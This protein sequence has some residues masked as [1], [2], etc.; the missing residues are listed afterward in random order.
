MVTERAIRG[1]INGIGGPLID[2][3]SVIVKL[4]GIVLIWLLKPFFVTHSFFNINVCPL[5]A[6]KQFEAYEQ[7]EAYDQFGAYE[8]VDVAVVY[9][10]L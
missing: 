7:F 3:L 6:Y 9:T 4:I 1:L 2:Q 8:H 5:T 10:P